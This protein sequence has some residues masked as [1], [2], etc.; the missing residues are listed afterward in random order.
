[1]NTKYDYFP[2]IVTVILFL[3]KYINVY[4][5]YIVYMYAQCMFNVTF[6]NIF[7]WWR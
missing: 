6:N 2:V 3:T 7:V 1:M 5:N 4:M